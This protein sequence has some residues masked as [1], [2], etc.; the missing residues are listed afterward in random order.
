MLKTILDLTSSQFDSIR[1]TSASLALSDWD[2]KAGNYIAL[3]HNAICT[4]GRNSKKL[5]DIDISF[6][7][8]IITVALF[9]AVFFFKLVFFGISN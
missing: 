6:T 3:Y 2:E 5:W 8:Y 1:L 7:V 4:S 9:V